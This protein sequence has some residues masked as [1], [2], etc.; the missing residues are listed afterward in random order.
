MGSIAS[1]QAAAGRRDLLEPQIVQGGIP[2]ADDEK[3]RQRIE[4]IQADDGDVDQPDF[5]PEHVASAPPREDHDARDSAAEYRRHRRSHW[6][7]AE[8]IAASSWIG[9]KIRSTP[10]S[11]N[12]GRMDVERVCW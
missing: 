10:S 9:P 5:K 12:W 4:R 8:A 11:N 6:R 2:L 1:Y 7:N 3:T